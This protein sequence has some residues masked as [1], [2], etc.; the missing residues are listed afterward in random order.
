VC[1]NKLLGEKRV[2]FDAREHFVDEGGWS[3]PANH[4]L[5]P[6]GALVAAKATL[7]HPLH[8]R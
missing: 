2:P 3:G 1:G 7:V 5:D 8:G 4:G 6:G